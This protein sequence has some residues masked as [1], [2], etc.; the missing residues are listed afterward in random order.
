MRM[1]IDVQS[2][3]AEWLRRLANQE[4]RTPREQASFL[5]HKLIAAARLNPEP[6]P[7]EQAA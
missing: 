5:L 6:S 4:H 2:E 7:T 1:L 3:D